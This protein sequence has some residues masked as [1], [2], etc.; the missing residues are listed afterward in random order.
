V[1]ARSIEIMTTAPRLLARLP[2]L[3]ST[4][5]FAS[6]VALLCAIELGIVAHPA[7]ADRAALLS[8]AVTVDLVAGIPLLGY[9]LLV[10]RGRHSPWLLLP[11]ALAAIGIAHLIVPPAHRQALRHLELSI[12]AIELTLIGLLVA[13]GRRLV[14]AYR[15]Q[16]R[17]H[18]CASDALEAAMERVLGSRVAA[19]ALTVEP[20]LLGDAVTGWFRRHVPDG[21]RCFAYHRAG[22]YPAFLAVLCGLAAVETF[23]LHLLLAMWSDTAAWIATALA[24]YGLL[25]I[26][27]DFHA[28]RLHPLRVDEERLLLRCGRRWRATVRRD[29]IVAVHTRPPGTKRQRLDLAPLGGAELWLELAE[30]VTASGLFG[31]RRTTR[32]IGV[33]PE[34]VRGFEACVRPMAGGATAGGATAGGAPA[35]AARRGSAGDRDDRPPAAAGR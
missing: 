24:C 12:P 29:A 18:P 15:E 6:L 35:G 33:S 28:M 7:F 22:G 3:P 10:R 34:D 27:G 9:L 32:F 14:R 1:G 13:R 8:L 21:G 5:L 25:W 31:M 11:L 30:P 20:L 4:A 23:G 16:R 19:S 17:R 2:R 26:L